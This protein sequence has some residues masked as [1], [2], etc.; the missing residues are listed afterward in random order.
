MLKDVSILYCASL[1]GVNNLMA[2]I[3]IYIYIIYTCITYLLSCAVLA[4]PYNL[5]AHVYIYG[6]FA[7]MQT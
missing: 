4:G 3:Y 6:I 5:M 1:A 7:I 2:R